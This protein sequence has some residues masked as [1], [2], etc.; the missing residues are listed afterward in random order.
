MAPNMS[1]I[2]HIDS[3]KSIYL[4]TIAMQYAI[5]YLKS[6]NGVFL[7]KILTGGSEQEFIHKIKATFE[8]VDLIK[9]PASKSQSSELY[10]LARNIK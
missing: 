9:P 6:S 4:S 8:T 5:K 3:I 1:G 2:R 10:I 7:T